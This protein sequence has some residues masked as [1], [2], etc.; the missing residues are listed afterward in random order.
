M[1]GIVSEEEWTVKGGKILSCRYF[2]T[3]AEGA[4]A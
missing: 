3:A 2:L 1:E 4:L